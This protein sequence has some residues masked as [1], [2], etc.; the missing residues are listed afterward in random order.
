MV[1]LSLPWGGPAY[2][3]SGI[4][5]V[6]QEIGSLQ[7]NLRQLLHTAASALKDPDSR[8]IACFLPRNTDMNILGDSV[9]SG[10]HCLVER[11]VLNSHLKAVTVYYGSLANI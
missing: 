3:K 4:F 5:D 9:P 1:F 8:R 6:S 11:N 2:S 10:Q 7:Q